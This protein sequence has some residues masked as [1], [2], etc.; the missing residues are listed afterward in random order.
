MTDINE[1][2]IAGKDN[3]QNNEI[4]ENTKKHM[5]RRSKKK[6]FLG[7]LL[8]LV[9]I[10]SV[11]GISFANKLKHFEDDGPLVFMMDKMTGDLN[12]TDQQKSDVQKIKDEVKTKMESRKSDRDS[13]MTD[14]ETAFRQD[15][16]DKPTLDAIAD[17]NKAD[18][19]DMKN[20]FEDELIKFHSILSSTQRNQVADKIK[21]FRENHKSWHK[22][23][24]QKPENN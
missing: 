24:K 10:V 18:R 5:N 4:N 9:I 8:G 16:L 21:D 17:K 22:D 15:N 23:G 14:F 19:E 7:V 2:P 13:K 12:L 1:F 3:E 11:V 20:F 6:L